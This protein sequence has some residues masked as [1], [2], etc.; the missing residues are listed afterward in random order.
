[1]IQVTDISAVRSNQCFLLREGEQW[2]GSLTINS[3]SL[4][5]GRCE[6]ETGLVADMKPTPHN[7]TKEQTIALLNAVLDHLRNS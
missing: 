7:L 2:K 6:G 5:W 4:E 3:E 1:M